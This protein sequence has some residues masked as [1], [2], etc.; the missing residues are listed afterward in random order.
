[1]RI[2]IAL[3]GN[4][5]T[6]ADGRARPEDQRA[7]IVAAAPPIADLIAAGHDILLTHGNGP[8]VGN[9]LVKNELSANHVPP[10]S[11][12]WCGAQTQATI[13]MLLM[14]ALD[15]EFAARGIDRRTAT[16]VSRTLVSVDDPGF[17]NPTKPIGRYLPDDEA[18]VMIEHGQRYIEVADRGWR[19]VVASPEPLE[20][21]DGPAAD[22]MVAAG[23]IVV[24]SGGGGIPTIRTES[25]ALEGVEAVI[26][27]DLTAS[28]IAR[29]IKA[30]L[31]VIATDVDSAVTDWG[32]PYAKP[33]GEVTADEMRC[34][35]KDQGFAAGSM[36]PKIEAVTRFAEAGRG[37][38]I[39]TS[40]P[41]IAQAIDGHLGTR[42]VHN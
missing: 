17:A 40:L 31:L 15:D 22:V 21:L 9:L 5:M 30:D 7:A 8:Q 38:G 3:G 42:V 11:L 27:K 29:Q 36:G 39:I 10:V 35:A 37:T 19:R 13:G 18:R 28:L 1:M 2:V 16:L 23:Y 34:I 26:D 20:C 25:G 24:C 33:I 41:R 4:A 32:T 6:S 12:D 14:N